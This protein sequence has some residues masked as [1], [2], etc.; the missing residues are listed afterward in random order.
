[1]EYYKII[2]DEQKLDE[3]IS[4]LSDNT[5]QETYYICL[6][7]RHK[8]CASFPTTGSTSQLARL[9]AN[10]DEIKNKLL[11][12]ECPVGAY[13]RDGVVA[14]QQALAVYISINPRSLVKANKELIVELAKNFAEGHIDFNPVSLATT[15]IHRSVQRKDFL[16]FDFDGVEIETH[17]PTIKEVLP[18]PE[19]FKVLKTRGGFHLLVRTSKANN[20]KWYK[21]IAALP[22]CDVRGSDTL[23]PIAGCTQGGF[24][25][26]LL[27]I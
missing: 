2:T 12:L 18:D 22:N 10:K 4:L 19:S 24:T 15:A 5:K 20:N 14:S 11:R 23:T 7:G 8:Y 16:D 25:P 6:F 9:T 13:V 27:K 3:F 17:L 1:M 21:T 26:S